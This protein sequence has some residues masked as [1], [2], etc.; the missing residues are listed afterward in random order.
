M[1]DKAQV[2]ATVSPNGTI[3]GSVAP[4]GTVTGRISTGGG[5]AKEA[6][7]YV[8]QNLTDEQIAQARK[9]IRIMGEAVGG[10]VQRLYSVDQQSL[11]YTWLDPVTAA[12]GA[13]ILNSY[14][15]DLDGMG[16]EDVDRNIATGFT[17]LAT[18][19]RT[20]ARGNYSQAGGWWTIADG[21][22]SHAEGL[23]SRTEGHF[24]HA[25]GTRT[26][27]TINNAHSEG[28]MTQA[29]GRQGHSE[30]Q[31]TIAS[32]FCSHSEGSATTSSGYYSHA[33]GWGTIAKG[34]NQTA[35][36]K[37][38]I[39]DTTSL[40]I[41]GKGSKT[42]ASNAFTVSSGGAGW[43]AGAV[44]SPGAD[45]AELFEWLDG[46]PNGEDR[47]GMIVALEGD[48]IR[49]AT[50]DDEILGVISGTAM[51]LGDN[52]LYEW[53]DKYLTDNYGRIIYDEPV[54]E[55][56]EYTDYVDPEDPS[57]WVTVKESTGFHVYPKLNPDYNPD[58]EY[59][60]RENRKEWDAVGLLGKL[61]INDDGSCK[62][63][64]YVKVG[65]AGLATTSDE[66]TNIRVM[67]RITDNIILAMVK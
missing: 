43:F 5:G 4:N 10:T 61:H 18:G 56:I 25:E 23:L 2:K 63:G 48:K 21:Q 42:T 52:A 50:A 12:D 31:S 1:N 66:K 7:L 15:G 33:E 49:P 65:D 17:A 39:A 24:C 27:A 51:V 32:G 13:E 6:V 11:E 22:C 8:E 30:G 47:V 40:L 54:E 38:N 9:N 28:D 62:V 64:S 29:T 20:Q 36:G 46:N 26:R 45:Y 57:T 59:I 44:T 58:E 3:S 19:F 35:M 60:S 37:Y 41:V 53:K 16:I 14:G 55:F 34:K 67:K